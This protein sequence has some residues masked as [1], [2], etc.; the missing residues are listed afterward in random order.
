[1]TRLN[2]R[3]GHALFGTGAKVKELRPVKPVKE[4]RRPEIDADALAA[5]LADLDAK[6]SQPRPVVTGGANVLPAVGRCHE[7]DKPVTGE[8]RYCGRCMSR[9][10]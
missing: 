4:R 8:R 6:A 1:M 5:A 7:C 10:T 9:R 3:H 2:R